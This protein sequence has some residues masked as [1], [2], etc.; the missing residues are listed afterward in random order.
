MTD[1]MKRALK[2]FGNALGNCLS[3][4]DFLRHVGKA[5]AAP[6]PSFSNSEMLQQEGSTGLAQIRKRVF[7]EGRFNRQVS[8][9]EMTG[10]KHIVLQRV[11]LRWK[12]KMLD[13][14]NRRSRIR[15]GNIEKQGLFLN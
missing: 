13:F 14:A 9:M 11:L 4:K 6:V 8:L 10:W 1:G 12:L 3:N 5:P 7:D 2:S 15:V